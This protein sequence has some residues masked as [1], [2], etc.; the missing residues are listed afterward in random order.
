MQNHA[1]AGFTGRIDPR[2]KGYIE[3]QTRDFLDDIQ[4]EDILRVIILCTVLQIV[5]E[6]VKATK[7]IYERERRRLDAR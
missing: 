4:F 1:R 6:L 3:K 5:V 7:A 2:L